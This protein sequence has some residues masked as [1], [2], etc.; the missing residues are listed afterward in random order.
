MSFI[1][2]IVHIF[3]FSESDVYLHLQKIFD[4]IINVHVN[5]IRS[6]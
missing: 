6:I 5:E 1:H 4:Q 2:A 3:S